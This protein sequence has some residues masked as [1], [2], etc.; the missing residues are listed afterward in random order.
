MT[1][2]TRQLLGLTVAFF[3]GALVDTWLRVYGPPLPVTQSIPS[4]QAVGNEISAPTVSAT[5][6]ATTMTGPP[7]PPASVSAAPPAPTRAVATTGRQSLRVPI[8]GVKVESMKGG[9]AEARAGHPHEAID[10]LAPRHTPVHAVQDGTVAKL[11][12]SKAGGN[13]IY[14]FDPSGSLC[15]YYAHLQRYAE[16]LHEGG[17]VR[18]GQVVGYVGTSG[19]APPDTPHLHFAVFAL[20]PDRRWWKGQAI[21]PYLVFKEHT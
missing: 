19:N 17:T 21:D 3:A 7:P 1:R 12:V 6:P 5:P 2:G 9:F 10:I 11:F 20:G 8:D 4:D 14:Q 13:T 15:Y 16:G 18:Q